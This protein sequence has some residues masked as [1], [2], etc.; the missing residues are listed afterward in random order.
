MR[1]IETMVSAFDYD[2]DFV[3]SSDEL[4]ALLLRVDQSW[5]VKQSA[6]VYR[7][8]LEKYD[9]NSD[10]QLSVEEVAAYWVDNGIGTPA[11]AESQPL[12]APAKHSSHVDGFE[13]PF[14]PV[15][16]PAPAAPA[17]WSDR[18]KGMFSSAPASV[19]DLNA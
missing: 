6:D 14:V 13:A 9:A 4:H 18:V 12:P 8:L 10:G 19:G 17:A 11:A 2:R 16:A 7:E 5:T 15:L 3:V 1:E